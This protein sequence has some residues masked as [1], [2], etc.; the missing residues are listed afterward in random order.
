MSSY[1]LGQEILAFAHGMIFQNHLLLRD[2]TVFDNVA[3]ALIIEGYT[4]K[5]IGKRVDVKREIHVEREAYTWSPQNA[6]T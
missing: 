1:K 3:F 6:C 5:E 4:H 2:H